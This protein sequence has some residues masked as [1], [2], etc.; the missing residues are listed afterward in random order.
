[1]VKQVKT[2]REKRGRSPAARPTIGLLSDRLYNEYSYAMWAGV[3]DA[4]WKHEINLLYFAGGQLHATENDLFNTVFELVNPDMLDGLVIWSAL[5]GH[6]GSSEATRTFC[7]QYRPLPMV[8]I[9]LALEGIPSILVDNHQG[10]H[11]LVA[12]LIQEHGYRRIA[13]LSGPEANLEA[14]ERYRGYADALAEHGIPLDPN[15]VVG[16]DDARR[17]GSLHDYDVYMRSILGELA[18]PQMDLYEAYAH[19]LL[20]RRLAR[21]I[22]FEAIVGHDDFRTLRVL[23]ILKARGVRVPD[24]V[25]IAGFDDITSARYATPPLTTARQP[26]YELGRQATEMLAALLRGEKLPAQTLLPMQI[27]VRQSCGC[28]NPQVVRAA[29]VPTSQPDGDHATGEAFP[30]AFAPRR[31]RTISEMAQATGAPSEAAREWA[32]QL[33]DAFVADLSGESPGTFLSALDDVRRRRRPATLRQ[34]PAGDWPPGKMPSRFCAARHCLAW[35]A[36]SRPCS[37]PKTCGSRRVS[38]QASWPSAT[39]QPRHC[40]LTSKH[41]RCARLVKL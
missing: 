37:K 13:Y 10:M 31:E 23:E 41:R 20:A 8:S 39:G 32:E 29:V 9:G 1:M 26:L 12:H 24:E 30:A 7:Q 25:A 36:T 14:Q 5:L 4:A 19:T 21:Q 33:V 22:D 3:A 34:T 35:P 38:S 17:L 28:L 6:W 18:K 2:S 27:T 16:E 15:L 11:D 40:R